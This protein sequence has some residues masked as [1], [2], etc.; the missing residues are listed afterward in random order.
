MG[1]MIRYQP[2]SPCL[3]HCLSLYYQRLGELFEELSVVN[4][5][6]HSLNPLI[7]LVTVETVCKSINAFTLS[8]LSVHQIQVAEN[9]TQHGDCQIVLMEEDRFVE[10]DKVELEKENHL[11]NNKELSE[12]VSKT[13]NAVLFR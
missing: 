6:I 3:L 8:A 11:N 10:E 12:E 7:E 1:V 9:N 2:Y 13:N 4:D 5:Q